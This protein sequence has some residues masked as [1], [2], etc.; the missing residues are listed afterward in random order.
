[1]FT[2]FNNYWKLSKQ[3]LK[4]LIH[5][6]YWFLSIQRNLR[7]W[8]HHQSGNSNRMNDSSI[9]TQTEIT[10]FAAQSTVLYWKQLLKM[11][12]KRMRRNL[13]RLQSLCCLKPLLAPQGT[14]TTEYFHRSQARFPACNAWLLSQHDWLKNVILLRKYG[15]SMQTGWKINTGAALIYS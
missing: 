11:R 14:L 9:E 2:I 10:Q 4:L 8:V 6:I 12:L 15:S 7:K 5:S 13:Q 1:M 3:F